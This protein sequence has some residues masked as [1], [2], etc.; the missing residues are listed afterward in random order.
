MRP[1]PRKPKTDLEAAL[2]RI[3]KSQKNIPLKPKMQMQMEET[4]DKY[5]NYLK[6]GYKKTLSSK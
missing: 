5:K 3:D 2:G 6:A 4:S 1:S